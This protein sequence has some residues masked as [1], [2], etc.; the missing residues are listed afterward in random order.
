MTHENHFELLWSK[1]HSL[2]RSV[3]CG[4]LNFCYLWEMGCG[5]TV[6]IFDSFQEVT[7]LNVCCDYWDVEHRQTNSTDGG[8]GG[9]GLSE[10]LV[11]GLSSS[12][13]LSDDLLCCLS[14]ESSMMSIMGTRLVMDLVVRTSVMS[15]VI[16][17]VTVPV[18]P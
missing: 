9:G 13:G 3:V 18:S 5:P 6:V 16:F 8:T 4:K 17:S 10:S 12:C 14:G 11:G 1:N 15:L 2:D 7:A